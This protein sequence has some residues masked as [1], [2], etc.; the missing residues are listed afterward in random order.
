MYKIIN[1]L[2]TNNYQY[3]TT[4]NNQKQ[5]A[6]ITNNNLININ[7]KI[8]EQEQTITSL[9][10]TNSSLSQTNLSLK[11]ESS[12][13]KQTIS[14]QQ[15][16]LQDQA[17]QLTIFLIICTNIQQLITTLNKKIKY[18]IIKQLING[19]TR[20]NVTKFLRLPI[21]TIQRMRNETKQKPQKIKYKIQRINLA[22]RILNDLIPMVS[23]R[24]YRVQIITNKELYLYQLKKRKKERKKNSFIDVCISDIAQ[25]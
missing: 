22:K 1:I 14:V 11:E 16:Q 5:T 7:K 4:I 6:I 20:Q 18:T 9:Q 10:T 12:S 17:Q 21:I 3:I 15:Q 24:S 8:A 19:I 13:L 25:T 2:S 23:G